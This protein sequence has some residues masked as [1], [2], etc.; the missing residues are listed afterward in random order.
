MD[1]W[2]ISFET[3]VCKN[4]HDW[5]AFIKNPA[6][7]KIHCSKVDVLKT[8]FRE[9]N[10]KYFRYRSTNTRFTAI[11]STQLIRIKKKWP[12]REETF[13]ITTNNPQLAPEHLSKWWLR[14]AKS[15]L[16]T[17]LLFTQINYSNCEGH[18]HMSHE[19]YLIEL[20]I[21]IRFW[22][23]LTEKICLQAQNSPEKWVKSKKKTRTG[24]SKKKKREKTR[25]ITKQV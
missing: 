12:Q 10:S 8:Q 9:M 21:L 11:K 13:K 2:A 19:Q 3:N 7:A 15:Y 17:S 16:L 5:N 25:H 1:F 18:F 14:V 22:H 20:R 4:K 24:K 6:N 23:N